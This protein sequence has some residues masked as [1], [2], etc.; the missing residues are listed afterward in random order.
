M[1]DQL[2]GIYTSFL[3]I[4]GKCMFRMIPIGRFDS[5]E[6]LLPRIAFEM[7]ELLKDVSDAPPLHGSS[8]LV[9]QVAQM[10]A[11]CI[12]ILNRQH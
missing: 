6:S 9:F 12:F 4:D 8:E 5:P 1:D 3:L 2:E 10:L 7:S 11:H